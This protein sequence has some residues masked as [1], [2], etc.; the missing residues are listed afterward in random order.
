M[1]PSYDTQLERYCAC[2]VD[3]VKL[4]CRMMVYELEL[5]FAFHIAAVLR[6]PFC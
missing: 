5:R 2:D 6:C 4:S 1:D 3:S